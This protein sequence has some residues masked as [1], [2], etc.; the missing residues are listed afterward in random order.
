MWQFAFIDS[1]HLGKKLT[2]NKY[3]NNEIENRIVGQRPD[4]RI[5]GYSGA[6]LLNLRVKRSNNLSEQARCQN[7][8]TNNLHVVFFLDSLMWVH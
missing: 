7:K 4:I 8:D 5:F 2:K 1:I 3:P 6:F